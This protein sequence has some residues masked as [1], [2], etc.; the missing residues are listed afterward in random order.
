MSTLFYDIGIAIDQFKRK[1]NI[2]VSEQFLSC[3]DTQLTELLSRISGL[4]AGMNLCF[5]IT[6]DDDQL[7]YIKDT[8]SKINLKLYVNHNWNPIKITWRSKSGRIYNYD[9]TDINCADIEFSFEGLD[10]ALY[11]KQMYTKDPLPF[12]LKGLSYDLVV[13]RLNIN[14]IINFELRKNTFIDSNAVIQQIADFINDYNERSE[15]QDR[16]N[17]VVHNFRFSYENEQI[18]CNIDFGSTGF[19]FLKK[20]LLAISEMNHFTKVVIV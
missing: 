16:K 14:G 12:K 6:T 10:I 18:I 3:A 11:H 19:S 15:K 9:D 8:I 5:S 7:H 13:E 4:K 20:L 1:F 2:V 17:G